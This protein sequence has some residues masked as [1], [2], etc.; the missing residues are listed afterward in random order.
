M[1]SNGKAPK[2]ASIVVIG[3]EILCG[4]TPDIN[5]HWIAKE[6]HGLGVSVRCI[7]TIPDVVEEIVQTVRDFS[8]RHDYVIVTGGIGPT[9][10]DV[11]RQAVAEAFN[12]S[13]KTN[14]EAERIIREHYGNNMNPYRLEMAR[15]PEGSM[16]IRNVSFAAPGFCIENVF[17]FPGVPQLMQEMFDQIVPSLATAEIFERRIPAYLPESEFSQILYS[18]PN[19]PQV[20]VGSYPTMHDDGKWSVAIIVSG[21]NREAVDQIADQVESQLRQLERSKGINGPN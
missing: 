2:S 15:L 11:T 4:R 8:R 17:V 14:P 13:L 21:H 6:L 10:D 3:N 9:P 20:S 19:L 5:S 7:A 16:L 1:T 18:L 12:R